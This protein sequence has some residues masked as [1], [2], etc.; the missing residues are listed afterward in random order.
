MAESAQEIFKAIQTIEEQLAIVKKALTEAGISEGQVGQFDGEAMI[1]TDG[2]R[3]PVPANYASK[4]MLV[5]GDTLRMV[6]DPHG[7]DQPRFKQIDKVERAK[8]T[9][10]VTRKDGKYEILC[11]EGSFKVLSA[12]VKHFEIQPGDSVT[13]QFAKQHTKGS[14]AAI[15]KV[16]SK[17]EVAAAVATAGVSEIQPAAAPIQHH[18]PEPAPPKQQPAVAST[19]PQTETAQ[20][21]QPAGGNAPARTEKRPANK[22]KPAD[23]PRKSNTAKASSSAQSAPVRKEAPK[24]DLPADQGEISVPLLMDED[25]L[26]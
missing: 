5:P 25:D 10:L 4:S 3:I 11:E 22:A 7:G 24:M 26:T 16:A 14:W 21:P 23:R 2:T 15:E 1:L 6:P 12:A 20:V 19:A 13:I 8:A 18:A 9:G 17:S